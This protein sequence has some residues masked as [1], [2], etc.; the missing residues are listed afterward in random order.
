MVFFLTFAAVFQ[1]QKQRLLP[2]DLL[3]SLTY[4]AVSLITNIIVISYYFSVP[5]SSLMLAILSCAQRSK[6]DQ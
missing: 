3:F 5:F 4:F 2:T 1:L 6:W